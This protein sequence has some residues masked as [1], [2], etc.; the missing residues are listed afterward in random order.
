MTLM[1]SL[2]TPR[3]SSPRESPHRGPSPLGHRL[4]S[5][6]ATEPGEDRPRSRAGR[7]APCGSASTRAG[8]RPH[9]GRYEAERALF[10][11]RVVQA[12]DPVEPVEQAPELDDIL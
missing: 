7:L 10:L 4:R 2:T 1:V 5:N 9:S 8:G 11:L 12:Q 3:S 6:N